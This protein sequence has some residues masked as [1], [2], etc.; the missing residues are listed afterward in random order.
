M[1]YE[2]RKKLQNK[3][4]KDRLETNIRNKILNFKY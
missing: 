2:I 3:K 4:I 1:I